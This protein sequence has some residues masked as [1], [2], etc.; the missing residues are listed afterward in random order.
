MFKQLEHITKKC[1]KQSDVCSVHGS[2]PDR[3]EGRRLCW[4]NLLNKLVFKRFFCGPK[5]MKVVF[6]NLKP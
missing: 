4:M 5:N 6:K 2:I 3:R 1:D